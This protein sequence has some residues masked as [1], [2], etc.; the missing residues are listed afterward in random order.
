VKTVSVT[1]QLVL[2]FKTPPLRLRLR[3]PPLYVAVPLV[4]VVPG[5]DPFRLAGKALAA[6]ATPVSWVE[7]FGFEIVMVNVDVEMPF[8]AIEAGE[9]AAEIVGALGTVT[10]SG[11]GVVAVVPVSAGPVDEILPVVTE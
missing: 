9:N 7:A 4:Q 2:A 5:L 8:D 10:V 11:V 6:T 3:L 1:V